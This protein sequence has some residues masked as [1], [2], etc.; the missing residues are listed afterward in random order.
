MTLLLAVL[1]DPNPCAVDKKPRSRMRG[2]SPGTEAEESR[3]IRENN[4]LGVTG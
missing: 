4:A 1:F 2:S 3:E